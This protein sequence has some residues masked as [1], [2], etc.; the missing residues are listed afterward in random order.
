MRI[1]CMK[2]S[3]V[4]KSKLSENSGGTDGEH[5]AILASTRL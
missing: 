1:P 2:S 3:L 5:R 4:W